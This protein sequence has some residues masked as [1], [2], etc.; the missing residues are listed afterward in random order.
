[1]G[2]GRRRRGGGESGRSGEVYGLSVDVELPRHEGHDEIGQAQED[3]QW[4]ESL[5][6]GERWSWL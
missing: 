5:V 2:N 1:M 3:E 6:P 4:R